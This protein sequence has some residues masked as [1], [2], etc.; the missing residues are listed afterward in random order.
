MHF[1]FHTMP[2]IEGL[3][4]KFDAEEFADKLAAAHV[5]YINFT[6]R[7]NIGFSYYDTKLGVRY[8]GLDRDVVR[9]V[10]DACH[11]R[12]IGISLYMNAGLNHELA[13]KN[14]GWCRIDK[15]GRIYQPNKVDNFFRTMC[16]NTGYRDYVKA[17]LSELLEYDVDGVFLDCMVTRPCYCPACIRKMRECGVDFRD[18]AA[19]IKYQDS[20]VLEMYRE[21]TDIIRA[22]R[23]DIYVYFNSNFTVP[24]LHTHAEVEC[25]PSSL[26]WGSDYFFPAAT[27]ARAHYDKL[28][29]MTGRFADCWG[30]LGGIK[31]LES[32]QHDLYDAMLMGYDFSVGDHLHPVFGLF[33][34]VIDRVGKVFSEKMLYEPY[35]NGAKYVSEIALMVPPEDYRA[36]EYLKG[37]AR[38]LCELKIPYSVFT[39]DD[40]IHGVKLLILPRALEVTPELHKKIFI[41]VA[42][43]GKLLFIGEGLDMVAPLH[44]DA[45]VTDIAPDPSD[46]SYFV[47]EEGGM[48]WSSYKPSR[49][50]KNKGARELARYVSGYFNL[51]F[52]GLQTY[53]YRPQNEATEYSAAITDGTVGYISYNA[54]DAYASN[55]LR[56]NKL[57]VGEVID[58][59]LPDR[60][61]A[62]EGLPSTA[63]VSITETDEHKIFHLKLTHPSI[64]NGRGI[65]EDH[66]YLR[67]ATASVRGEYKVYALPECR[68][69]AAEIRDGRTHFALDDITGYAAFLLK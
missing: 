6:A 62:T 17:E 57:L 45:A 44:A 39:P 54:F 24:G 31:P 37:A 22:R 48:L 66:A 20:L 61:I 55:F 46:N 4:S 53:F 10:V 67:H 47:T 25:L 12:D 51:E 16:Y 8:P 27:F 9:E 32:M 15:E 21:F 1:D 13:T 56:E 36:P 5:E 18:D 29:Y 38:M 50:M 35:T 63:T 2:G 33:D 60:M 19:V 23:P 64:R 69:I 40:D 42:S 68:E 43:G 30:D 58:S 28:V 11:K 41:H 7:C 3:F 59:L 26:H 34:E 65:V 49:L 14:H 52:D